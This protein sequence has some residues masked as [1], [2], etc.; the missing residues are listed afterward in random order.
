MSERERLERRLAQ[1][2]LLYV[3]KYGN[4]MWGL[5]MAIIIPFIELSREEEPSWYLAIFLFAGMGTLFGLFRHA[6]DSSRL[7]DL[8]ESG[9][10]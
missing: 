7:R 9:R 1:P 4:L 2:R 6:G 5:P 10:A 8:R 3:L